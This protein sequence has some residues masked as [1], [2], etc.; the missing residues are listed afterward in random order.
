MTTCNEPITVLGHTYYGCTFANVYAPDAGQ[1]P[2]SQLWP[3]GLAFNTALG[4]LEYWSNTY[5]SPGVAVD[6]RVT[7]PPFACYCT[8]GPVLSTRPETTRLYIR[9]SQAQLPIIDNNCT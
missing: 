2:C 4:C 7:V 8:V 1:F 3:P 6:E 9:G 5:Q